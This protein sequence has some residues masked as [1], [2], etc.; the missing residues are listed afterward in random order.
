MNNHRIFFKWPEL[1][2]V[3]HASL[4]NDKNPEL[5]R[6]VWEAL[7]FQSILNNAVVTD[8]SMYCWVPMLSFD[9]VHYKERIDLAPVG[10]LRYSQNTGNKIILQYSECNENI[11]GAVLGQVDEKDIPL[12]QR[13]GEEARKAI[14]MTKKP[15]HVVISRD[16]EE[17]RPSGKQIVPPPASCRPEVLDLASRLC[18]LADE[19]SRREPEEL[20]RVRTG[21]NSGMGSCGQ[22]FSTWEF[23]YS[24]LRDVSMYTLYPVARIC[25]DSSFSLQQLKKIYME[26]IPTYMNLLGSYGLKTLHGLTA[27]FRKLIEKDLLTREE[28]CYLIDAFVFYTNMLSQ[29]AYFQYPWGIG[30][31]CFRFDDEHLKY[32]PEV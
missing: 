7:P 5:C 17:P 10:R 19:A 8:G 24:L 23:V 11:F 32:I 28:F 29:W 16:E 21:K 27:E 30:S 14:F 6:H 13:A 20:I 1:N 25:R 3:V 22:Y 12:L 9:P 26:I 18:S 2:I 15:L 31:A 4:A